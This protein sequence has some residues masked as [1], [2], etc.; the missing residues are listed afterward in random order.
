MDCC[1]KN[2]G[3]YPHNEDAIL[4]GMYA[5]YDGTYKVLVDL[6]GGN[7]LP[8][9]INVLS[10]DEITIPKN[11][12]N[13]SSLIKFQVFDQWGNVVMFNDGYVDVCEN[14]S[15]TTYINQNAPCQA[16]CDDEEIEPYDYD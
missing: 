16:S 9:V 8:I 14:L 5:T 10:G 12:L 13:E 15:L 11:T 6:P 4:H 3:L 7:K 2:F 1:I